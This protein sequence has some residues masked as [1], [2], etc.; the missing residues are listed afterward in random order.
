M[1]DHLLWAVPNLDTGTETFVELSGIEAAPGGRHPGFG[2]HNALLSLGERCYLELIAPDPTQ[3]QL[4]GLGQHLE[5]LSAPRLV[6]WCAAAKD[7]A[8]IASAARALGFEPGDIT[9][10]GRRRP[11]GLQLEWQVLQIGGHPFGPLL[12]FF[13]FWGDTPHPAA[14]SPKGC[15]LVD[16]RLAHPQAETLASNLA[17]LGLDIPVDLGTEAKLCAQIDTA[18]GRLDLTS[19]GATIRSTNWSTG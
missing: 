2:T 18:R 12:P 5:G 13:I 19:G 16:F 6:T 11:N 8:V 7:L 15:R 1:I 4:S 9:P 3:S 17:D 10:M 14:S